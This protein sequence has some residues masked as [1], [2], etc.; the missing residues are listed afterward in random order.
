MRRTDKEITCRSEIDEIIHGCQ[1]CH[2]GFAVDGE[3]YVV[4]VSFGYDGVALYFHTARDGRKIDFISANPRVCLQFERDVNLVTSETDACKF[5][6]SFESVIEMFHPFGEARTA[7]NYAPL[8]LLASALERSLFGENTFGYHVVNVLIHALNA[9]LFVAL[10]VSSRLPRV[11]A[12]LGGFL[13]LLHPANVEAVAWISQ[14]KTNGSLAF[15]LGAVLLFRRHPRIGTALFLAGLLT[16]ASA[17]AALPMAAALAW[18]EG[19]RDSEAARDGDGAAPWRWLAVW[20]LL[21]ALFA[22]PH[23]I[24]VHPRDGDLVIGTHGRSAFV[25]DVKEIKKIKKEL[26]KSK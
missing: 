25:L 3:P 22:V 15:T 19:G 10:L 17:A 8:H 13:F 23:Y 6:F 26:A 7:S 24:A 1:V 16:K 4:P 12:L 2:V 11:P 21:L 14:L 18:S 20:L 9:T 5:T